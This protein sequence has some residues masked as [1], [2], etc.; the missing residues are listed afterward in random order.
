MIQNEEGIF[1]SQKKYAHEVLE[2]FGMLNS[3]SMKNPIVP[4]FRLSKNGGGA[5]VDATK[6]KQI[7]GSLMYLTAMRPDLMYSVCLISRFMERPTELHLQA[8]KRILRYLKGMAELGIAYKRTG[9]ESLVGFADSDYAGDTDDRKSTSGCVFMIGDGATSW[10]S[11][12]QP[13]VTLSTTEAKFIAA[14]SC[15]CQG[16]WLRRV[17]EKLGHTQSKCT[18]KYDYVGSWFLN[19]CKIK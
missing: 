3:N 13:V 16:V 14:A 15:A 17:L 6:F 19:V 12:K 9:E 2:R 7:I 10:S 18:T 1:I 4:G 11:K 5:A 8:A